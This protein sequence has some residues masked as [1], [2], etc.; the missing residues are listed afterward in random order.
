MSFVCYSD[1]MVAI[2]VCVFANLHIDGRTVSVWS[3]VCCVCICSIIGIEKAFWS[4]WS[5]ALVILQSSSLASTFRWGTQHSSILNSL[6]ATQS[7]QTAAMNSS[8]DLWSKSQSV[9]LSVH[10]SVCQSVSQSVSQSASLSVCQSV[11]HSV[12]LSVC[13]W[14]WYSYFLFSFF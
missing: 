13:L 4:H 2:F 5:P 6:P 12:C 11:S 3:N 7:Q 9:C 1:S 8:I 14:L 10:Q